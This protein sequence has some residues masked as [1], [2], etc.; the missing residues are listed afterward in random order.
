MVFCAFF[1][2]QRVFCFIRS[3]RDTNGGQQ[4]SDVPTMSRAELN[5]MWLV[6][7]PSDDAQRNNAKSVG[8]VGAWVSLL[9]QK[10]GPLLG[11]FLCDLG[12][13]LAVSPTQYNEAHYRFATFTK[14]TALN[15]AK[16]SRVASI[17]ARYVQQESQAK[18]VADAASYLSV[19]CT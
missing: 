19:A 9:R 13:H 14:I 6:L 17:S 12:M 15:V 7:A 4:L 18:E 11:A 16:I 3:T 10:I 5:R 1:L 8:R 2:A